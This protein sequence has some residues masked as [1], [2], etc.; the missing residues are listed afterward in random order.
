MLINA[1]DVSYEPT[2]EICRW[3][4]VQLKDFEG[5]VTQ[6]LVGDERYGGRVSTAIVKALEDSGYVTASGRVYKCHGKVCHLSGSC[7]WC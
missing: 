5:N 6:H 2:C 7:N 3:K 4:I 1:P